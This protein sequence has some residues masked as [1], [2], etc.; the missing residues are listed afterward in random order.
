MKI[1][2]ALCVLL[3]TGCTATKLTYTPEPETNRNDAIR[4][5]EQVVMEQPIKYRPGGVLV[6]QDYI[7]FDD[8]TISKTKSLGLGVGAA[9]GTVGGAIGGS[10]SKTV[11][12][13]IRDRIYFNSIAKF[14][15]Y[16]KRDWYI[17]DVIGNNS[18]RLKR[19]YTLEK[20][21]AEELI[22][23]L[24]YFSTAAKPFN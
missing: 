2:Y 4:I 24:S 21:K 3:L 19:F 9:N 15:L 5:I 13:S 14:N 16:K 23:S 17:V 18:R 1:W 20:N 10:I 22:D 6:A 8:G 12:K 7:G 11:S